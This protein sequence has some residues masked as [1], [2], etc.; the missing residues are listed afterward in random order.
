[1]KT[2]IIRY[3]QHWVAF[4]VD[5]GSGVT[6]LVSSKLLPK[7]IYSASTYISKS[8]EYANEVKK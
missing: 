6:T 3:K 8:V 5:K 7:I 4:N 1:L 2:A